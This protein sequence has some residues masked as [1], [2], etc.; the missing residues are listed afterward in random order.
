M[1]FQEIGKLRQENE[2]LRSRLAEKT[3]KISVP[4][5]PV[6]EEIEHLKEHNVR[7]KQTL[8][9]QVFEIFV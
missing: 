6:V 9:D 7:L 2:K 1:F 4:G 3:R 8:V 5:N